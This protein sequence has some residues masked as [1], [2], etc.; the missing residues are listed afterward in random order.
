[1]IGVGYE[2]PVTGGWARQ[3]FTVD[4]LTIEDMQ[5]IFR[6]YS[7]RGGSVL[8]SCRERYRSTPSKMALSLKGIQR[9]NSC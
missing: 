5:G 1:M 7:V 6:L 4:K 2:N 9:A 8:S 3:C